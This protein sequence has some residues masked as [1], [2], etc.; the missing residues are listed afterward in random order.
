MFRHAPVPVKKGR[1]S[2]H[3]MVHPV[4]N[5]NYCYI[6]SILSGLALFVVA[7]VLWERKKFNMIRAELRTDLPVEPETD[8]GNKNDDIIKNIQISIRE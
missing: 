5:F 7:L 4:I 8:A 1:F 2:F 3:Q 6:V